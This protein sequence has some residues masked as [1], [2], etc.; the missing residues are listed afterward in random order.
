MAKCVGITIII[1]ML[2]GLHSPSCMHTCAVH[3]HTHTLSLSLD[4]AVDAFVSELLA[5]PSNGAE[6]A[7][8]L[9]SRIQP[10][11]SVSHYTT[12]LIP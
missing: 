8:T 12:P 5:N 6:L 2:P 11:S 4:G 1:H 10:G 9:I 7:Q 3:A